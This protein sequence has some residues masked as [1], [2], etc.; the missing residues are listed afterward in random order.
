M[1]KFRIDSLSTGIS[2]RTWY[3]LRRMKTSLTLLKG[4]VQNLSGRK[5]MRQEVKEIHSS[6]FPV[7]YV[8]SSKINP[9]AFI[10][11]FLIYFHC[12]IF[13]IMLVFCCNQACDKTSTVLMQ[14]CPVCIGSTGLQ[15]ILSFSD[16]GGNDLAGAMVIGKVLSR[17][18]H[19]QFIVRLIKCHFLST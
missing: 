6:A 19:S 15:Q 14:H 11:L 13:Q 12:R 10:C 18:S 1:D 5:W 2:V 4:T 17:T 16:V 3:W 7:M 8:F 9:Q